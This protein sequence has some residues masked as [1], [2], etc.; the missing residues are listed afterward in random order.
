M[1]SDLKA[2]LEAAVRDAIRPASLDRLDVT[3]GLDH[4]GDPVLRLRAVYDDSRPDPTGERM[5]DAHD[6]LFPILDEFGEPRYPL[7]TFLA[8]S[9]VDEAAA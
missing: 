6:L 2:R 3:E 1:S 5:L 4:D 7:M 8:L 9:E